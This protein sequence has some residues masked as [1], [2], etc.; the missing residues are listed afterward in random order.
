MG[1]FRAACLPLHRRFL[2]R[3]VPLTTRVPISQAFN[4]RHGLC[5]CCRLHRLI[6][7]VKHDTARWVSWQC[8]FVGTSLHNYHRAVRYDAI[9][10]KRLHGTDS[11]QIG[12]IVETVFV[13][14]CLWFCASNC[15]RY[16]FS[17]RP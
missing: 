14:A 13:S 15:V 12:C 10:Y 7:I 9:Q 4:D 8:Q 2:Q 1:G 16:L 6:E 3:D 5:F 17:P 11:F